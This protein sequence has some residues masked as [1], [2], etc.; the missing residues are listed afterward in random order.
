VVQAQYADLLMHDGRWHEALV[1]SDRAE[2]HRGRGRLV[3]DREFRDGLPG[4]RPIADRTRRPRCAGSRSR[5]D[6]FLPGRVRFQLGIDSI[7]P[8]VLRLRRRRGAGTRLARMERGARGGGGLAQRTTASTCAGCPTRAASSTRASPTRIST[9]CSG[10]RRQTGARREA[11]DRLVASRGL[12]R[13]ELAQRALPEGFAATRA[14]TGAHA[15]WRDAQNATRAC[16]FAGPRGEVASRA[17]SASALAAETGRARIRA[18]PRGAQ[19]RRR[20]GRFRPGGGPGAPA[21]GAGAD[22]LP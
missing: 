14:I 10:G 20:T 3:R 16:S 6:G 12:I 11:W 7:V 8:A 19:R 5:P 22:C 15:R 2:E 17:L 13:T 21:P 9:R 4:P 18:G 1:V